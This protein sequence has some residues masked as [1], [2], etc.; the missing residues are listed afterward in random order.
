MDINPIIMALRAT[1][2]LVQFRATSPFLHSHTEIFQC[3]APCYSLPRW[4]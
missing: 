2:V 3:C 1:R 4:P